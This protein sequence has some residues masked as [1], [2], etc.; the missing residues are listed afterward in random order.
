MCVA[1]WT[2]AAVVGGDKSRAKTAPTAHQRRRQW[3]AASIEL[4]TDAGSNVRIHAPGLSLCCAYLIVL[5]FDVWVKLL[6]CLE[7]LTNFK[8]DC[9]VL[10]YFRFKTLCFL[11]LCTVF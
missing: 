11:F 8:S 3:Q 9:D 1:C 5:L 2:G 6:C 10:S 4:K 7:H